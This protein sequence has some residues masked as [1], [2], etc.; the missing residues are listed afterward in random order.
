[1][2]PAG[3]RVANRLFNAGPC[4]QKGLERDASLLLNLGTLIEALTSIV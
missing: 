4:M 2:Q 1:M 3:A